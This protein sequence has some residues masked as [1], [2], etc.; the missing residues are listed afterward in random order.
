MRY[1]NGVLCVILALFAIA[2]YNDPDFVLWFLIYGIAAAWCG[3]AAFRLARLAHN[4]AALIG[5]GGC[6]VLAAAGSIYMWPTGIGNWWDDEG[7][8]EGMGLIIVTVSLAIAA[9]AVWRHRRAA[10]P[11]V[12]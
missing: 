10:A 6:L 4:R 8:R 7:V 5:L 12:A 1:L 3:L 2:Q 11:A 9:L